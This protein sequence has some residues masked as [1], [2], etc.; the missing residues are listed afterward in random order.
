H[1]STALNQGLAVA[2][3][4]LGAGKAY[5]R[6]PY[7]FSDQYDLGL[8]YHGHGAGDD[9]VVVR[10]DLASSGFIAFW[11]REGRPMAAMN[12]NVWDVGDDLRA[13]LDADHAIPAERLRDLDVPLAD[14]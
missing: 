12:V 9:E 5:D 7:F 8:E 13:V 2:A 6:L 11:L 1:W 14:L 3:N 10:G 4:M